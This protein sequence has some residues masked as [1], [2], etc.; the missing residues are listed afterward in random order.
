MSAD[1]T[2]GMLELFRLWRAS[3]S[4]PDN[5]FAQTVAE[6]LADRLDARCGP[7]AG[8]R[9]LDIG[10]GD[11]T[12]AQVFH[13]RGAR[14]VAAEY[15][16]SYLHLTGTP[17]PG[18]VV[19]DGRRLPLRDGSVDGVF[20]C[21]VLEH[22]P[23]PYA[24]LDDAARVLKPGGWGFVNWTNWYSPWGGHSMTPYQYLGPE[25]GPRV[26]EQRHGPPEKNRID[27]GLFVLHIGPVL[28]WLRAHPSWAVVQVEPRYWPQH[29]WIMA[30]PGLR[31]VVAWNCAVWLV[32]R[33][34]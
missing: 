20:S 26:Y 32:K 12:Y 21:N 31:E 27:E 19:A 24:L 5:P 1:R 14:V 29:R 10:T 6:L 11:G 33:D 15:E 17:P 25:R 30:V 4:T 9:I 8:Q 23:E 13:D 18:A 3:R 2:P 7:L 16:E 34:R 28:R 22:T